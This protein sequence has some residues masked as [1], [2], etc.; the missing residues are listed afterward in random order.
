MLL[1]KCLLFKFYNLNS[2][3]NVKLVQIGS[4]NFILKIFLL[5]KMNHYRVTTAA[6]RKVK[7]QLQD[8][9]S[10]NKTRA[11]HIFFGKFKFEK[12]PSQHL[13]IGLKR[14]SLWFKLAAYFS[15]LVWMCISLFIHHNRVCFSPH[16]QESQNNLK[17]KGFISLSNVQQLNR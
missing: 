15:L 8:E 4:H 14:S 10:T 12:K 6:C 3:K 5:S 16:A 11:F 13:H 2:W 17:I 1:Y 9:I 7:G